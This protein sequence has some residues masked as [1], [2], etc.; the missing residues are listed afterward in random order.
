M[1]PCDH[2]LLTAAAEREVA[3]RARGGDAKARESLVLHNLRLVASLARKFAAR[4]VVGFDDL[5]QHGCAGLCKAVDKFD[6]GRGF[7]FSTYATWW[8]KDALHRACYNEA[9]TV[10]I[11]IHIQ[12]N[13]PPEAWHSVPLEVAD[14][15]DDANDPA[16][17]ASA[18]AVRRLVDQLPERLRTVITRRYGL[19]GRAPAMLDE[20]GAELGGLSRERVRQLQAEGLAALRTLAEPRS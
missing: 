17:L 9:H 4:G 12:R 16:G 18:A 13:A 6:P 11:P 2:D 15:P 19:D 14:V 10:R 8:I 20:V 5:F 3:K 7:R 1:D